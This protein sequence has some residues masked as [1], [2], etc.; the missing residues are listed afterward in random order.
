VTVESKV[1]NQEYAEN[2]LNADGS[3]MVWEKGLLSMLMLSLA[4]LRTVSPSFVASI[5]WQP[6]QR[7]LKQLQL[8]QQKKQQL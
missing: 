5:L 3:L 6:L 1:V 8:Q 2:S 7:R 4:I